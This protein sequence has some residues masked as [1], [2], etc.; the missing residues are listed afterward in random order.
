MSHEPIFTAHQSA[1]VL[2]GEG[3]LTGLTHQTLVAAS[4]GAQNTTV[5]Q[6]HI[7]VPLAV[8]PHFH[9]VEETVVVLSGCLRFHIGGLV[10]EYTPGADPCAGAETRDCG[11]EA[12]CVIPARRL[13]GYEIVGI[14]A[15][16]LIIM[17]DSAG[18]TRLPS[19]EAMTLPW[20]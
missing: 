15:R 5:W 20:Q 18:T 2:N 12:T 1:P 16:V 11:P 8:P 3:P 14:P 6:H 13:H 9:D 4:L 7:T 10:D 19:G 17:P